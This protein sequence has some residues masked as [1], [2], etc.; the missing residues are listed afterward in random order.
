MS[1][2]LGNSSK[3]DCTRLHAISSRVLS[4]K[5][6]VGSPPAHTEQEKNQEK[7]IFN[8]QQIK[9]SQVFNGFFLA[10]FEA[11]GHRPQPKGLRASE[12]RKAFKLD[13]KTGGVPLGFKRSKMFL[14]V[15]I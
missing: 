8:G 15:F 12:S 6:A 1:A 9:V 2:A 7:P 14:L 5:A 4:A 11:G 13:V 3:L 10:A